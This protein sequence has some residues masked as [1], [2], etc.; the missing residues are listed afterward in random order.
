ME[1][2]E[3]EEEMYVHRSNTF[4]L[5][6]LPIEKSESKLPKNLCSDYNFRLSS[7]GAARRI[8]FQFLPFFRLV[9]FRPLLIFLSD[10]STKY[11]Y[12]FDQ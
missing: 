3:E 2:E 7:E 8:S 12:L 1:E 11:S 5:L 10:F 4:L 6:L 9:V